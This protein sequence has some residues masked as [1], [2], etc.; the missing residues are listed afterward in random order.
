MKSLIPPTNLPITSAVRSRDAPSITMYS[1]FG[2]V[3]SSTD[4]MVRS[5]VTSQLKQTVTIEILVIVSF[6]PRH[7]DSH[8]T[9]REGRRVRRVGEGQGE[10]N[11]VMISIDPFQRN[12]KL[13]ASRS[14]TPCR[15][16]CTDPV[17][18]RLATRYR[19]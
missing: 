16:R 8:V 11:S 3:C 1:M 9:L 4:R 2:C 7:T 19:D 13:N 5:I 10:R 12:F 18:P 15:H 17:E 14:R 6:P